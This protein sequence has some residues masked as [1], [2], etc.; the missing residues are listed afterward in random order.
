MSIQGRS[1]VVDSG[2]HSHPKKFNIILT[3]TLE[4]QEQADTG[5]LLIIMVQCLKF[6]HLV[7][8]RL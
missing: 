2:G 3:I 4:Q 6:C 8:F 7:V 1:Y 5:V